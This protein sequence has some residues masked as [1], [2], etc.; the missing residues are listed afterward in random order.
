MNLK[1]EIDAIPMW[2]VRDN[3]AE[4]DHEAIACKMD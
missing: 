3:D 2:R 4:D 1:D